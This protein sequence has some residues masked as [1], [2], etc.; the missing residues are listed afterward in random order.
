MAQILNAHDFGRPVPFVPADEHAGCFCLN[1][2]ARGRH[3]QEKTKTEAPGC[4]RSLPAKLHTEASGSSCLRDWTECKRVPVFRPG[5]LRTCNQPAHAY[6]GHS[7]WFAPRVSFCPQ[8]LSHRGF[9]VSSLQ[10][11]SRRMG[12]FLLIS[13]IPCHPAAQ[14]CRSQHTHTHPGDNRGTLCGAGTRGPR[15]LRRAGTGGHVHRGSRH[16]IISTH[17]F[18]QSRLTDI[19]RHIPGSFTVTTSVIYK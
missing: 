10:V 16:S 1:D 13:T 3:W 9:L 6:A 11:W 12:F 14:R 17:A 2:L 7:P 8:G 4:I 5:P 19:H 15:S 18:F